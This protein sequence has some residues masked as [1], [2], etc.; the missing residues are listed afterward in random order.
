MPEIAANG[1]EQEQAEEQERELIDSVLE[2]GETLVR[3]VMTPR[4]DM[5]TVPWLPPP[6]TSW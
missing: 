1:V 3:E 2:F 4:P 5:V 6:S